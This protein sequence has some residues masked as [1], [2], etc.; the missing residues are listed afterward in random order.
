VTFSAWALSRSSCDC[1]PT[2]CLL[3]PKGS[4]E[5]AMDM[6]QFICFFGFNVA[7]KTEMV[8]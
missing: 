4:S 3:G 7:D 8:H 6:L 1:E 5:A 2:L